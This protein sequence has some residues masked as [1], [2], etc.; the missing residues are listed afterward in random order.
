MKTFK[1]NDTYYIEAEYKKTRSAFKH[2]ATLY[3][4]SS[5]IGEEYIPT[6]E[7]ESVKICYQNRTWERYEFEDVLHK[8][9]DKA[10]ITTEEQTK[11]LLDNWASDNKK[12]LDKKFGMI[13]VFAKMG[14]ILTDTQ[15]EKNNWKMRMLK[16]GLGEGLQEPD[17]WN[18]LTEEVKTARLERVILELTQ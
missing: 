2:T 14:E 10:K 15:E 3:K 13:G 9:L 7:I 8:L 6:E 12:E 5:G 1:I 17:D 11:I 18:T 16:A 4:A